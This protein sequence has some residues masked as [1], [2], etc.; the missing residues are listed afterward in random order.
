MEP[1]DGNSDEDCSETDGDPSRPTPSGRARHPRLHARQQNDSVP[2]PDTVFAPLD[3]LFQ[4]NYDPCPLN[5]ALNPA[6]PDALASRW[7]SMVF[8]NPPY[9]NIAPW[10]RKA[11]EEL[12]LHGT[13]SVF[14]I[15]GHTEVH[16][17]GDYVF[18]YASEI[19]FSV[20]G[21][22]FPGYRMKMP[23]A[24]AIVLYGDF[25]RRGRYNNQELFLGGNVFRV[26]ILRQ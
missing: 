14:L 9:S 26:W 5:G 22:I 1:S 23:M 11:S 13:R 24:M 4:F 2:T 3:E 7:G 19:W 15:P 21:V 10:V 18:P 12:C 6:V 16:Y 8:C 25:D 17:W 20:T